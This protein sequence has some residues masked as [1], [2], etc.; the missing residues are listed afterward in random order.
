MKRCIQILLFLL[1]SITIISCQQGNGLFSGIKIAFMAGGSEDHFFARRVYK[2]AKAAE[3]LLGCEITYYWSD[4]NNDKMI[5]DFMSAID[6][7][8]DAICIMGHPGEDRMLPLVEQA[9]GAGIIVTSQNVELPSIEH[10]FAHKGFGYVGQRIYESGFKMVETAIKRFGISS[11]DH[12]LIVGV[13]GLAQRGKRSTA[14]KD[15]LN[16]AGIP[17]NYL[18]VSQFIGTRDKG[19]NVLEAYFIE[20][21]IPDYIFLDTRIDL[22]YD[23][24]KDINLDPDDITMCAFDLSQLN[25]TELQSG[26]LDLVQDQQPFLQG[27]L[28]VIN[29]CLTKR[30]GHS[31]LHIETDAAYIDKYNVEYLKELIEMEYR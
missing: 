31:G 8:P 23:Y 5:Y 6:S 14:M 10:T 18:E 25:Y 19:L 26:Y 12:V 2:G 9:I 3:E 16:E 27:F 1:L 24:F 22:L 28:P 29:A 11:A 13:E 15:K 30:F 7:S 17:F 4:W 20:H 21:A